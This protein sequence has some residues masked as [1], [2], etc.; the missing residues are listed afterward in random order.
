MQQPF[1]DLSTWAMPAAAAFGGLVVGLLVRRTLLPVLARAA[2]KSTFKYDDILVDALRGPLVVWFV[3]IG[4][5]LAVKL[6]PLSA[7]T[8]RQIGLVVLVLGILAVTWVVARFAGSALRITTAG[9]FRT[10]SLMA[11]VVKAFVFAI[12]ILIILQM[13]GISIAPIITALGIGGLAVGLALQD[14]LANF[15]A[16]IRILA[17]GTI[18]VGDFVRL[19]NG[20]EGYVR[21]IAWA[22]T[23]IFD[24]NG[25]IVLV[26]NAKLSSAI[27]TN[28]ARPSPSQTF[29]VAF[30]VAYG[31]DLARVERVVL[32]V[33]AETLQAVDEADKDFTP[34]VRFRDFGE[35]AV[36]GFAVLRA[37]SQPDRWAVISDFIKRL[38]ARFQ[39][40]GIEVPFPVRTIELRTPLPSPGLAAPPDRMP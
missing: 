9:G 33:A 3:L 39:S 12:G 15:F 37:R 21:D 25:H 1:T 22:Q 2:A 36:N 24:P 11:N 26:P 28:F 34:T 29:S 32:E 7:A 18:H 30:G 19:E 20:Q 23:T 8:D 40:E 35:S 6:L 31:S 5:R 13:L 10:V 27:T 14:T 16:G 4:L 38:H 17:A